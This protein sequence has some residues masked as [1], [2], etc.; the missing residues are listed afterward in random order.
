LAKATRA[1]RGRRASEIGRTTSETMQKAVAG[2][3]V[4][5][6]KRG[7]N[8]CVPRQKQRKQNGLGGRGRGVEW[9]DK[10]M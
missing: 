4:T 8:R 10:G 7:P 1:E 2:R 3:L 9:S 5:V 6:G